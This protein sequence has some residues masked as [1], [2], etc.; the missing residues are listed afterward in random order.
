[1]IIEVNSDEK[2][3]MEFP[4]TSIAAE[5][6]LHWERSF[7]VRTGSDKFPLMCQEQLRQW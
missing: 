6:S 3:N 4:H 1:M 2:K 7:M 5:R